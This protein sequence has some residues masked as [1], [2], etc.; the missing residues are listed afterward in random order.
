MFV[1]NTF[2]RPEVH[3]YIVTPKDTHLPRSE[4]LIPISSQRNDGDNIAAKSN[5][6]EVRAQYWVWKNV[7]NA[8]YIGFFHHRRYLLIKDLPKRKSPKPYFIL[9]GPDAADYSLEKIGPVLSSYDA[10]APV[11][12][13]TGITVRK[14]YAKSKNHRLSDLECAGKIVK[15]LYPMFTPAVADYLDGEGEY[16][17]NMYILSRQLFQEYCQWLFSILKEFDRR[18]PDASANT[19]GYI[20]ERLFGIWFTWLKTQPGVRCGEMPRVHFYQHDDKN[21]H[22]LL[23]KLVNFFF[24]PGTRVR[25][26]IVRKIKFHI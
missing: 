18:V 5:Y 9:K 25:A 8:D 17:C 10:I 21:H 16:F 14:R 20:A 2:C 23:L 4:T 13:Y 26:S 6:C 19:D 12:E 15:E 11:W 24:P 3:L 1:T 22:F 7:E